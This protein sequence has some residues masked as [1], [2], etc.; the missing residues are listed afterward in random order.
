MNKIFLTFTVLLVFSIVGFAQNRKD[1]APVTYEELYDEPYAI[2]KLFVQFQPIYGELFATNVNAGFGLEATYFWNDK[3]HFRAH[4]RKAYA[5]KFDFTRELAKQTSDVEN[6]PEVFNYYELGGT[7]HIKDF[8]QSSKTKMV[9]YKKSYKG[10]R[11]AARVPLTA[12]IPSKVRKIYGGRLGGFAYDSNVDVNRAL[13]AQGKTLA[14]LVDESG[15]PIPLTIETEDGSFDETHVF[16]AI[17]VKGLYLGGS[18]TWIR[19]IAVDFDKFEEGVDDLI[20]TAFFDVMVAPWTNLD[21]I[22]YNDTD[23]NTGAIVRRRFSADVLD[24][25]LFG[26]RLGVDGKFNRT[27]SWGYGGEFGYRPSL[28]GRGFYMLL[29]ISFPVY[30]TNIDYGVEAF[31]K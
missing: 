1:K 5:S 17:D 22:I 29:K 12:E 26:F 7:Y 6:V 15:E 21:D 13:T 16:T 14:D 23:P 25:R 10:D 19:N 20:L 30:S 3:A 24:T 28:Q 9:L 11:W 2:N 31:G 27:L 18:M 4:A 8:E